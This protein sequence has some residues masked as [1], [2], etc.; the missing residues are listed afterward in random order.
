VDEFWGTICGHTCLIPQSIS[1]IWDH[2]QFLQEQGKFFYPYLSFFVCTTHRFLVQP[3]HL[4]THLGQH[5]LSIKDAV[6]KIR[7]APGGWIS[8]MEHIQRS[9]RVATKPTT[10]EPTDT[11]PT[12]P[13][14]SLLPSDWSA[15]D[16]PVPGLPLVPGFKCKLCGWLL[17]TEGSLSQHYMK[18]HKSSPTIPPFTTTTESTGTPFSHLHSKVYIQRLFPPT[19]SLSPPLFPPKEDRCYFQVIN[20][21]ETVLQPQ[22]SIATTRSSSHSAHLFPIST[23]PPYIAALGWVEWLQST[24]LSPEF[25]RW[26]VSN[27][28][29]F[30]TSLED[31][32]LEKVEYGL[33]ETSKLLQEYLKEADELLSFLAPGIR[34]AVRGK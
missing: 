13:P 29:K 33:H 11:E 17:G 31:D 16:V 28:L 21:P 6:G 20:L 4:K 5:D 23:L 8:L 3:Y 14:L 27:P 32:D 34:D 15:I 22:P 2:C 18:K 7:L 12:T 24:K 30:G 1:A 10:T 9:F 26:L 25:L 19:H